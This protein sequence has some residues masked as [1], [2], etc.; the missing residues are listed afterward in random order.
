MHKNVITLT[1]DLWMNLPYEYW[2]LHQYRASLA[3]KVNHSFKKQNC[4]FNTAFNPRFGVV[5]GIEAARDIRRGEQ[6]FVDYGYPIEDLNPPWYVDLYVQ[7][8]GKLPMEVTTAPMKQIK[9]INDR[10]FDGVVAVDENVI[11]R[12]RNFWKNRI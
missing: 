6:I 5:R 12:K 8:V 7:E 1:D 9:R 4:I 3:H 10:E 2:N 11:K